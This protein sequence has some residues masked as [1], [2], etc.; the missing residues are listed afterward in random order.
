MVNRLPSVV[1]GLVLPVGMELS[2]VLLRDEIVVFLVDF[3]AL[4]VVIDPALSVALDDVLPEQPDG[5]VRD[6]SLA[7]P[8]FGRQQELDGI[9][10]SAGLRDDKNKE[11]NEIEKGGTVRLER[12]SFCVLGNAANERQRSVW[13]DAGGGSPWLAIATVV[14]VSLFSDSIRCYPVMHSEKSLHTIRH[15]NTHNTLSYVHDRRAQL[16]SSAVPISS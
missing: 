1:L 8:L 4:D 9:L 7:G 3:L 12:N 2:H 11:T 14:F 10:G 6:L 15:T 5:L 16:T 13:C